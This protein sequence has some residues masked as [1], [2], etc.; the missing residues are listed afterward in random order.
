M[1][2]R[3]HFFLNFLKYFVVAAPSGVKPLEMWQLGTCLPAP[4]RSA[5]LSSRLTSNF[6]R[7]RAS[8]V[9]PLS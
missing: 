9:T 1:H 6:G 4:R 3:R 8:G 5:F 7:L 2:F